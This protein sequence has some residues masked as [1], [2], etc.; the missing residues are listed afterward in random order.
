MTNDPAVGQDELLGPTERL[1]PFYLFTGLGR[2]LRNAWGFAVGGLVLASRGNVELA[3]GLLGLYL[4]ASVGA[5][6]VKWLK[7]EYR[8][9]PDEL[10]IETGLLSKNSRVIPFDRVTDIDI[11]QGPIHRLL[12]LARVR[13]ETGA[14]SAASKDE[15]MLDTISLERAEA[16]REHIRARRR[17]VSSSPSIEAATVEIDEA[18]PIFAMDLRRVLTAGVFN[19]SLAIVAGLFGATQTLGDVIGFDPFRRSFWE[20]VFA[21]S[22]PIR[23]L[24]VTHQIASA[25]AGAVLL[26]LVGLGTGIARTVLREYGFRL[27]RTEAGFRRRRGLLTLTDV[28]I[29]AKRVQAAILA[30][31]PV[32]RRFGWW[33]LKLQSLAQDGGQGDHVVAPLAHFDEAATIEASINLP[34]RP[35]NDRWRPIA[36]GYVGSMMTILVPAALLAVVGYGFGQPMTSFVLLGAGVMIAFRQWDWR[37]TRYAMDPQHLFIER[38]WWRHR[39]LVLPVRKIQS[40]DINESFWTRWFG[41]CAVNLG[42]AGG[43]GRSVHGIPALSR[44]DAEEL[45]AQLLG[46]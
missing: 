38:G 7:L 4:L 46:L 16:L 25:I 18:P 35:D 27:D 41:F 22:G 19:F 14:A 32:R 40:I 28:S 5:L 30:T 34:A 15:G 17:G 45:R 36:R 9:G 1:H 29:P 10:R 33:T 11:E 21:R 13:L 12:G 43:S 37:N 2:T 6:F 8:V 44:V 20:G 26:V 24:I 31:G 39:L 3:L 23:D 42:I